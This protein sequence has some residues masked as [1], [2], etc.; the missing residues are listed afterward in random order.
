MCRSSA[1]RSSARGCQAHERARRGGAASSVSIRRALRATARSAR[2]MPSST[3]RW[4]TAATIASTTAILRAKS[5]AS[6]ASSLAPSTASRATSATFA[7]PRGAS[8]ARHLARR[9]IAAS[10]S[11][12]IATRGA[13]TCRAKL[14]VVARRV[15]K[16]HVTP[17]TTCPRGHARRAGKGQVRRSVSSVEG[18]A[19]G[20]TLAAPSRSIA[21]RRADTHHATPQVA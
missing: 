6:G 8:S 14:W 7:E 21:A 15:Q 2:S 11:K 10:R 19:L 5:A 12:S 13:G 3:T 20:T 16:K 9:S 4:W 17:T 1:R 18:L